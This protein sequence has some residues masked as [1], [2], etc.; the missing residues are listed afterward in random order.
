MQTKIAKTSSTLLLLAGITLFPASAIGQT[1][2]EEP[3][4]IEDEFEEEFAEETE[5]PSALPSSADSIESLREEYFSLRDRLFQSKAKA[6]TV[7]SALYST[8]VS[9]KLEYTSGRFYTVTRATIRLDGATLY[10]DSEGA[11]T[12]SS[13]PPRFEGF[14]APGRHQLSIRIES[15]GKDDDR[16]TSVIENSFSILAVKG[17]DLEVRAVAKDGG[18]IPFYWAKKEKGS[19]KLHLDVTIQTKASSRSKK[20]SGSKAK[21][22]SRRKEHRG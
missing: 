8:R 5:S 18:N 12:K 7:A 3:E 21:A 9:V 4:A 6:A 10:D 15:T 14:I 22:K 16:F 17:K 1:A 20:R 13:Q 11:I 2:P 19:Y